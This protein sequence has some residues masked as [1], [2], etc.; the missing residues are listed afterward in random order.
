M[1]AFENK[2]IAE[3]RLIIP[4]RIVSPPRT[5]RAKTKVGFF[6]YRLMG[7]C[8]YSWL[9][10]GVLHSCSFEMCDASFQNHNDFCLR[11]TGRIGL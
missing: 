2:M 3:T 7:Y 11:N 10:R 8:R 5:V 1:A 9:R 4:A 6:E